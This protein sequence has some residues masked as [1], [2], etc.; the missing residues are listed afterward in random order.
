MSAG[1]RLVVGQVRG[2]HGLRGTVRVESLTDRAEERFAVGRSLFVEGGDAPLTIVEAETGRAAAGAL[3]FA[4]VPDRTAAETL[5]D[6]Y[7]E[8]VVAPGEELPRGE[9]YW[10]QVVGASVTD[11]D[12]TASRRGRRRLPRRRRRGRRGSRPGRRARRAAR[13]SGRPHLRAGQRRDRRGRRGAR[14]CEA[15]T[16]RR[17]EPSRRAGCR[18][19]APSRVS[20][21]DEP[22]PRP[23]SAPARAPLEIE[24]LTLFPGMLAGPLAESIPGRVQA[25]GLATVRVHDLRHW[26]LGRHKTVD[27]YTYGG[28]AGMVLRPEPV[29]AALDGVAAARQHG[30]PAGPG[31]RGLRAGPRP[32]PG[33]SDPP[34]HPVPALRG[35]G[36]AD[37]LDGG[38]G[39]VDRGLR[40]L[41]RRDPGA[42]RGGHDPAAAARRHRR[43]VHGRGV[44]RRGLAGVPA[45]HAPAGCSATW[46]CRP[47]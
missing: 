25:R 34:D 40:A 2:F 35:R 24:I 36:R 22:G 6:V 4:E 18:S 23:A 21:T 14:A 8:A 13:A 16:M 44:V 41:R 11:T 5:R 43:R 37:P 7:L 1:E 27:D 38:P 39:A 32:R 15:R 10:H 28:G 46:P 33:R 17:P 31:R 3:R 9:F 20:E 29:A 30:H 47:C 19:R 12:G 45:V 26:G 42:G